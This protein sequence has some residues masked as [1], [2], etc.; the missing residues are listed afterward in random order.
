MEVKKELVVIEL[1][2]N[3]HTDPAQTHG[4]LTVFWQKLGI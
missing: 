3:W 1:P 4:T 2:K